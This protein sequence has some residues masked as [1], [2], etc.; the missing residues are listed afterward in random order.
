MAA[1]LADQDRQ[2]Y[3]NVRIGTRT[4]D[5]P[6]L[7]RF[8]NQ[9]GLTDANLIQTYADAAAYL[10]DSGRADRLYAEINGQRYVVSALEAVNTATPLTDSNL[11]YPE[12]VGYATTAVGDHAEATGYHATAVGDSARAAGDQSTAIGRWP[13]AANRATALGWAA[14][15]RGDRS[16]AL[17]WIARAYGDGSTALGGYAYAHGSR[18]TSAGS[19]SV[20]DGWGAVSIGGLAAALGSRN[21]AVGRNA[22]TAA[23]AR[24]QNIWDVVPS[25]KVINDL[26]WCARN[27]DWE[28]DVEQF[29]LECGDFMTDAER[30]SA[31]LARR[32]AQGE[33]FRGSIRT[34]LAQRLSGRVWR[35]VWTNCRCN[36]P[37]LSGN[38]LMLWP[39]G[40]PR[41]EP[42]R[43]PRPMPPPLSGNTL[44][45]TA[46][47]ASLSDLPL[48]HPGRA[49]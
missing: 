43:A 31:M 17:G 32:D 2:N 39:T 10:A 3:N 1:Y 41:W 7:D 36:A 44:T 12:D 4:Y 23:L 9:A 25:G 37:P 45:L 16:T 22:T 13:Y 19:H 8:H 48:L 29:V 28:D 30:N 14:G 33:T 27:P 35:S 6:S 26:V 40:P 5:R 11:P 47:G 38:S 34:R 49:A 20:A 18:A 15:A 42:V 24:W 21:V 46:T